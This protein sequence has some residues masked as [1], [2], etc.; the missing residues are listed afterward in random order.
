MTLYKNKKVVAI[1]GGHGLGRMLAA[2]KDFGNN[3]TG[4]VTTTDNGGSTGRIRD[5]Q[6]GIAWGDT[7]NCINQLIT[8]PSIGSMMFEYRFKG[9]GELNDHNLGNLMLTA[10][11]NLSI[12]PLEA[13]N[14]IRDMLKVDINIVPMTEHPTD[15]TALSVSGEWVRGETSVDETEYDLQRLYLEP[16]VQATKEGIK[17]IEEANCIVLGPGSF[18]TSIM[19]PLLL[20]ELGKAIARNS[21]AKLVFVENLSPEYGPAGRMTLQEKLTWCQRACDGREI[22]VLLGKDNYEAFTGVREIV[23]IDLASAN[24][25]WRHDRTKLQKAIENLLG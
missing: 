16:Q 13:I 17:A 11:D 6:G 1:G 21:T 19:P 12:R 3:A 25:Q 4:I 10:L 20:P 15:L 18:L 2:L 22:D 7:R 5:C 24:H 8:E 23:T 14:L 9:V